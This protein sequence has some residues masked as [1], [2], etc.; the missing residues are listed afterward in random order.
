MSKSLPILLQKV[1]KPTL[2][3]STLSRFVRICLNNANVDFSHLLSNLILEE[4]PQ[5][6][7]SM[8]LIVMDRLGERLALGFTLMAFPDRVVRDFE[9]PYLR[10]GAR[11]MTSLEA[12]FAKA[13]AVAHLQLI[14]SYR[15]RLDAYCSIVRVLRDLSESFQEYGMLRAALVELLILAAAKRPSHVGILAKSMLGRSEAKH[16]DLAVRQVGETIPLGMRS[17]YMPTI[18]DESLLLGQDRLIEKIPG[19]K[20]DELFPLSRKLNVGSPLVADRASLPQFFEP[21][22]R[23]VHFQRI[24]GSMART[25]DTSLN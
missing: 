24:G 22:T 20:S 11:L 19:A 4:V 12:R 7:G 8:I 14:K 3:L 13:E 18:D 17:T 10:A 25:I 1:V 9:M 15:E 16:R 6:A 21:W 23:N 5:T 2:E